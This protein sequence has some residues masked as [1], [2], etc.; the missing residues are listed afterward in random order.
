MYGFVVDGFTGITHPYA[1]APLTIGR[2]CRVTM[3]QFVIDKYESKKLRFLITF[4]I[5][6]IQIYA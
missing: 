5:L 4:L 3:G 1:Y 2:K 6:Y